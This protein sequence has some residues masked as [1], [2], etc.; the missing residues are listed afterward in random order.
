[1]FPAKVQT[2]T[3]VC[4]WMFPNLFGLGMLVAYFHCLEPWVQSSSLDSSLNWILSKRLDL[5]PFSLFRAVLWPSSLE[6]RPTW[7]VRPSHRRRASTASSGQQ[8]PSA[9]ASLAL[10][11]PR[12]QPGASPRD[13]SV[14]P[15]DPSWSLLLSRKKKQ[16][17]ALS[18]E[19]PLA[20]GSRSRGWWR[21]RWWWRRRNHGRVWALQLALLGWEGGSLVPESQAWRIQFPAPPRLEQAC[22]PFC[23]AMLPTMQLQCALPDRQAWGGGNRRLA[24]LQRATQDICPALEGLWGLAQ[25]HLGQEWLEWQFHISEGFKRISTTTPFRDTVNLLTW[26]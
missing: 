8:R 19:G 23:I 3:L 24:G 5:M 11:P 13:S 22:H 12:A 4:M 18:C 26:P 25:N 7:S 9:S 14:C 2:K 21:Q 1:M 17:A 6:Q 15:A 10:T 16:K 20:S